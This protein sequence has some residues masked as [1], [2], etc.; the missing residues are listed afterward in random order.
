MKGKL[1]FWVIFFPLLLSLAPIRAIAQ[2]APIQFEDV[3][4]LSLAGTPGGQLIRS[5]T[6]VNQGD[7]LVE[8]ITLSSS[9]WVHTEEPVAFLD[10]SGVTFAPA[11][12]SLRP[13]Q[14]QQVQM[15]VA[16]LPA[17]A[18]EYSGEL[19]LHF[20]ENELVR[21][22]VALT[23]VYTSLDV[24]MASQ[25]A[26]IEGQAGNLRLGVEIGAPSGVAK[27]VTLVAEQL[28]HANG[29]DFIA[30][31]QLSLVSG[32]FDLRQGE[33]KSTTL[34]VTGDAIVPGLYEGE[35]FFV[36]IGQRQTD[37]EAYQLTV[38]V[39]APP[40]LTLPQG[41]AVSVQLIQPGGWEAAWLGWLL[42]SDFFQTELDVQL[43]N[44]TLGDIKIRDVE[45]DLVRH[46]PVNET[47]A[48]TV[49]DVISSTMTIPAG[50]T[51]PLILTLP[52]KATI[53]PGAYK[54]TIRL[55]VTDA[56]GR[57]A[58][59]VVQ[60]VQVD[61]SVRQRPGVALLL[62]LIGLLLGRFVQYINS[63]KIKFLRQHREL[64]D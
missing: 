12:F 63:D 30:P 11:S 34:I 8:T 20:G 15:T 51:I 55:F 44:N 23:L 19:S 21:W 5:F 45:V 7:E 38:T 9:S 31:D 29:A 52:A 3:T 36:Q 62:L 41:N 53:E 6:V 16:A 10:S 50:A 54:G 59:Q 14:S 46:G 35:I 47:G 39:L 58:S 64:D 61:M 1:R 42:P 4:M 33:R 60:P 32:A 43:Q 37:V 26:A 40:V 56:S 25:P 17:Q 18:G 2:E 22:P 28:T 24:V 57:L 27:G 48:A 13:G 49:L